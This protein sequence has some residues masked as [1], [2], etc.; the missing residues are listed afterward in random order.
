MLKTI[1]ALM[2]IQAK[3]GIGVAAALVIATVVGY[4]KVQASTNNNLRDKI[5]V[6]DTERVYEKAIYTS[7][8]EKKD[9]IIDG[10]QKQIEEFKINEKQYKTDLSLAYEQ[11]DKKEVSVRV[12]VRKEVVRDPSCENQFRLITQ[13]L[14]ELKHASN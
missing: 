14:K 9:L 6:C 12:E 11:I 4:I 1:F 7:E 8:I 2:P 10:L 13:Q 3:L 5:A